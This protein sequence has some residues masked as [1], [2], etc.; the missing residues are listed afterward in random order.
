MTPSRRRWSMTCG[1]AEGGEG[2]ALAA[3]AGPC[4]QHGEAAHVRFVDDG[5]G[6]RHV[7][8]P[9]VAPVEA[10]VDDDGLRHA[11]R[12]V[13]PVEGEIGARRVH[14]VAEQRIGPAQLAGDA[15]RVG[16]EQQ[17]VRVEAMAVL[18]ARRGRGRDSRRAGPA[19]ARADSRAR[20][21]RCIPAASKRCDLAPARGSNRHSSTLRRRWRRRRR[22]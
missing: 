7:G 18:R 13:A 19:R 20:P 17:L 3:A 5:V 12:A 1:I 21:R 8:R 16:I 9:I 6:P 2:A 11:R 15:P 14:A 22:N 10:V 4:A